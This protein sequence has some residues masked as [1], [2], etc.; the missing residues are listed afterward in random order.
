MK[1]LHAAAAVPPARC[2]CAH[3]QQHVVAEA[4]PLGTASAGGG[5]ALNGAAVAGT[6]QPCRALRP[7]ALPV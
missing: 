7:F 2:A 6:F 5:N 1:K 4:P 3:A